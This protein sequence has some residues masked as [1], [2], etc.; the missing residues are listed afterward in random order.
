MCERWGVS[1]EAACAAASTN[2][3]RLLD[4]IELET[5]SGRDRLDTLGM[6]P[7]D[8][9]Y[10]A[11]TIFAAAFKQ[12]VQPVLGWPVLV[13]LPCRDFVYVIAS[14]SPLIHKLGTVV[15]QEFKDSGYPI[16]T[17]VLQVSDEGIEALGKF[18]T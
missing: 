10:K 17:E 13:V 16:T 8:S 5:S 14:D 18:P 3:D 11:S 2:Q 4:G 12:L 7:V 6:I 15:V 1:V 9:P